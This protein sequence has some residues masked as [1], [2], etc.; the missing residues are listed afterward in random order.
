MHSSKELPSKMKDKFYSNLF[1]KDSKYNSVLMTKQKYDSIIEDVKR[2]KVSKKKESSRDYRIIERYDVQT[3]QGSEKLVEPLS[4]AR[5]SVKRFVHAEELFGLITSGEEIPKY[6]AA[7]V[8]DLSNPPPSPFN[9]TRPQFARTPP[10]SVPRQQIREERFILK[11][12]LFYYFS[13][14]QFHFAA[15]CEKKK[16]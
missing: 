4:D 9:L 13:R 16:G 3:I 15:L 6:P 8:W 11:V 10:L 2:I 14:L 7:L 5:E 12:F 1:S